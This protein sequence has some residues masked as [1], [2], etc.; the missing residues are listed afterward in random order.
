MVLAS[1][2][3]LLMPRKANE[4]TTR[5]LTK[6]EFD[7]LVDILSTGNE[8]QV[9]KLNRGDA[10]RLLAALYEREVLSLRS[11][12]QDRWLQGKA[13]LVLKDKVK[14]F[15][16]WWDNA[17]EG[18]QVPYAYKSVQRYMALAHRFSFA[19][20]ADKSLTE[21][22]AEIANDN[23]ETVAEFELAAGN[24]DAPAS[25]QAQKSPCLIAKAKSV[26]KAASALRQA[27][28]D[29]DIAKTITLEKE[30]RQLRE[31]R[32]YI[33]VAVESILAIDARLNE[34]G[35]ELASDLLDESNQRKVA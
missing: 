23:R 31:T 26:A 24:E 14:G 3:R 33:H 21:C 20:I 4:T 34:H 29:L 9:K 15:K 1:N 10:T 32:Q 6:A 11:A 2:W 19:E 8:S 16:E 28:S 7:E 35:I 12:T 17:Y 30:S 18:K 25:K 22:Y 27:I 5:K 13:L